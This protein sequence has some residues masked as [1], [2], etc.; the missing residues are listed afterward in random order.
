MS[1][2]VQPNDSAYRRSAIVTVIA[3]SQTRVLTVTQLPV[4]TQTRGTRVIENFGRGGYIDA[5]SSATT[6]ERVGNSNTRRPIWD[7]VHIVDNDFAI[8]NDTIG[9]YLTETSGN[10]SHEV[11]LSGS[12]IYY[13]NRQRWRLVAQS[14]GSYRIRSVSNPTLYITEGINVPFVN[15]NLSLASLNT[16]HNRQR[17]W[18]GYIWHHSSRYPSWV[19]FWDGPIKIYTNTH[20][21]GG[22][23]APA[24]FNFEQDMA[25]ARSV[26]ASALGVTFIDVDN[27]NDAHI[28]ALGGNRLALEEFIFPP[29]EAGGRPS[30]FLIGDHGSA[31]VY[32][33]DSVY[34]DPNRGFGRRN[35]STIQAGGALRYV[36]LFYGTGAVAVQMFVYSDSARNIELS[37]LTAIHELGHAL[38][39]WGHS[40]NSDDIMSGTPPRGSNL[41]L[42]LNPA[43]IEHL[44]QIYRRFRS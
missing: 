26:W 6:I 34:Q 43:E 7:F 17:W 39:S 35:V 19:A 33:R 1:I 13:N 29:R 38:G 3:G 4:M 42:T 2:T 25:V 44:R 12:G 23:S 15:P 21:S 32:S 41:R 5:F 40:P 36:D 18:I 11:R 37:T 31:R 14:D 27:P 22:A 28:W 16:S 9:R 8:R 20:F 10:L 30:G 24:G